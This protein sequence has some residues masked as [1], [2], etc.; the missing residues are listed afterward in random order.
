MK[1]DELQDLFVWCDYYSI[2]QKCSTAQKSAVEQLGTLA[3]ICSYFIVTA[4]ETLHFNTGEICNRETYHERC[5]CRAEIFSH[6]TRRGCSTFDDSTQKVDGSRKELQ[7]MFYMT[8]TDLEAMVPARLESDHHYT[9]EFLK[10]VDV[11]AGELTCCKRAHNG[12]TQPCDKE[13]LMLPMVGLYTEIYDNRNK[14]AVKDMYELIASNID[15]IFPP[16]FEYVFSDE[17]DTVTKPLFGD[18]IQAV[19]TVVQAAGRNHERTPLTGGIKKDD[20]SKMM[21][22]TSSDADVDTAETVVALG[23]LQPG[24]IR[25][26]EGQKPHAGTHRSQSIAEVGLAL[27][28]VSR[29]LSH[30]S[31]Q[32]SGLGL[33][34]PTCSEAEIPPE[35]FATA[36]R[37]PRTAR[38]SFSEG[39]SPNLSLTKSSSFSRMRSSLE[40]EDPN[41][42]S[43]GTST[44]STLGLSRASSNLSR[45]PSNLS[46]VPSFRRAGSNV[47][48][49][50][51][52]SNLSVVSE[53]AEVVSPGWET[54]RNNPLARADT[55]NTTFLTS[56]RDS[57]TEGDTQGLSMRRALSFHRARSNLPNVSEGDELKPNPTIVTLG[58]G[59]VDVVAGE[60]SDELENYLE[61]S[62][63]V[64][65]EIVLMRALSDLEPIE[66]SLEQLASTSLPP[67]QYVVQPQIDVQVVIEI[68]P[69]YNQI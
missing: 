4:P 43:L 44:P 10:A 19:E 13:T 62:S 25:I 53:D 60:S 52:G 3:S 55:P 22:C 2:P 49:S 56:R 12:G 39:C 68:K 34:S 8:D 35:R 33:S 14:P 29:R 26:T 54:R 5:W 45:L 69:E 42:S 66:E 57:K 27:P 40:M 58:G 59:P 24:A 37:S 16:T 50:R 9:K 32:T 36:P 30:L 64:E 17:G 65:P 38:A 7:N 46:R 6:W 1:P 67:F 15:A 47:S 61:M 23:K 63:T 51:A 20:T 21:C 11:F 41:S 31:E 48:L 28:T 18:L